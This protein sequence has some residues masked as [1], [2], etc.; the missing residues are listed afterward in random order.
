MDVII[1]GVMVAKFRVDTGSSVNIMNME[2][3]ELRLTN[4]VPPFIILKMTVYT[5][6]K[7]LGQLLHILVQIASREYKIDFIIFQTNDTIQP[8][9]RI[10]GRP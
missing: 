8:I 6:T 9:P 4:M 3:M 10:L 5:R 2:T 7:P 1:D